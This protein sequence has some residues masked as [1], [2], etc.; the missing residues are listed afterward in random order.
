MI[1]MR[2]GQITIFLSLLL[3]AVCALLL[4][5]IESARESVMRM[6]TE[7]AMDMGL[8]SIFAEYNREMLSRYDLFYIDNSYGECASIENTEEHLREY[9]EANISNSG[10]MRN[11]ITDGEVGDWFRLSVTDTKADT[12]LLASDR[13]GRVLRNQAVNY[14]RQYAEPVEHNITRI[15]NRIETAGIHNGTADEDRSQAEAQ[16]SIPTIVDEINSFRNENVL[17][18]VQVN[19]VSNKYIQVHQLASHRSLKSGEGQVTVKSEMNEEEA[20][21]LFEQYLCHK[22]SNFCKKLGDSALDYEVEY[23]IS[24]KGSD[25]ENLSN[26]VV[27]LLQMRETANV[28]F[29]LGNEG[30]KSE[31][32]ELAILISTGLGHPEMEEPLTIAILCAWGYAEAAIDVNCLLMGGRVPVMKTDGDWRLPLT[33]LLMFRNYMGSGGGRGLCYEEYLHYFLY[34]SSAEMNRKRCFDVME[35]NIRMA[36]GSDSF[37]ID[38][39][40]EYIKA[41]VETESDFGYQHNITRDFGYE[42]SVLTGQRNTTVKER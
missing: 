7:T 35:A 23:I 4:V 19:N 32:Q 37:Q 38:G 26:A 20:D 17:T 24:G 10:Y 30:K 42:K 36:E 25:R 8:Y 2:R 12:Y 31:A 40:V 21:K 3:S 41:A 22:C 27:R 1:A 13:N 33:D 9:I 29:L 18:Q 16:I 11:Q 5:I 15:V 6:Q 39:C 14:L 34:R 28:R